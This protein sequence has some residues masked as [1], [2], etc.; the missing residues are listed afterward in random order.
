MHQNIEKH[1]SLNKTLK[2]G[3]YF[4]IFILS[5]VL[6]WGVFVKV[7]LTVQAPGTFIVENY[8][9]VLA[10]TKGGVIDKIFVKEGDYVKKGD[11]LIKIDSSQLKS[12]LK[13]LNEN[14]IIFL[15]QKARINA[16]LNNSQTINFPKNIDLKTQKEQTK[17]FDTRRKNLSNKITSLNEKINQLQMTNEALKDNIKSKKELLHSYQNELDKWQKLYDQGLAEEQK[18]Y[19]LKR[20]II[21]L[22]SDIND[23]KSKIQTNNIQIKNLQNQ[24]KLTKTDYQKELLDQFDKINTQLPNIKSK[25]SVLK[26]EINKNDI[27]AISNGIVM[28]MKVHS[29]GEIIVPNKQILTIVPEK[30]SYLVEAM[31]SPLDIDKVQLNQKAE[32]TVAS[33]VDP[34]A[35][36]IDGKVIY[37]SPDIIKS[38]DGKREYYKVLIK[39]TPEGFRAIKENNFKIKPGMPVTVFIKAGQRTFISYMLT[40][41]EQ[42]LK[43]AFHAN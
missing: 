6:I 8:T 19:D 2:M 39:I 31:I 41:L 1:L 18:I 11:I 17:I 16:E 20:K 5:A 22:K 33:Y 4:I 13:S 9:K 26:N 14:Y 40:P 43:G 10:H 23:L 32:I 21:S 15:A 34:G 7:D 36:P 30:N 35:K 12:Q 28:D 27:K 29:A 3:S 38:S 24:I 37:I 25:I 42:L